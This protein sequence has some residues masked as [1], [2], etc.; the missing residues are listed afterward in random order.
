ME[1]TIRMAGVD[2]A[3]TIG[4]LLFDFNTE[5]ET[6]TPAPAEFAERLRSLLAGDRI[7]AFLAE[8]QGKGD[9]RAP[10][11]LGFALLSLRPTPYFDGPLVQLE[12][13]YV[14]PDLRDR[15]VGSGLLD[16]TVEYSLSR[17]SREIHIGVDEIDTDTRR[18]YE[19][20]GFANVQPGQDY[21]MLL[22]LREL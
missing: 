8:D 2:D 10:R 11:A 20:H 22:Y 14:V 15:G 4:R 18:F 19:R 12:E 17:G 7:V 5:F 1:H 13:L 9:S 16:A 3:D 6:P 21:R